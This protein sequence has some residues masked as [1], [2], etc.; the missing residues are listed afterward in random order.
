MRLCSNS[1]P[2]T[3]LR[4]TIVANHIVSGGSGRLC[5]K[6]R[7]LQCIITITGCRLMHRRCRA[8]ACRRLAGYV[9][10]VK[11]R[12]HI[13][14][15][16]CS[17]WKKTGLPIVDHRHPVVGGRGRGRGR[18]CCCC[19][20]CSIWLQRLS[21]VGVRI[22]ILRPLIR[23]HGCRECKLQPSMKRRSGGS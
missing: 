7:T 8:V 13:G 22:R 9:G 10:A 12:I 6:H 20:P 17:Q 23:T 1:V 4:L 18:R 2:L 5:G 15:G 19:K 16:S 14:N 3:H 11:R 21:Q